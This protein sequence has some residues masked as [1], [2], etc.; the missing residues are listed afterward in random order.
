[1]K[2]CE[3]CQMIVHA[4]TQICPECGFQFPAPTLNHAAVSYGG[5][6]LSSQVQAEWLDVED[7]LYARHC[8]EG[9][10]D[11]VKVTYY[12]GLTGVSEW[13]C[14]DH[15]GMLQADIHHA[16]RLLGHLPTQH[17]RLLMSAA[18]GSRQA[19]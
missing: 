10:P 6:M 2:T 3:S 11:S 1:V 15:G 13:L 7:V 5:A 16:G 12:C 17:N 9:K 19:A 4:A 8:K 18:F 14:P